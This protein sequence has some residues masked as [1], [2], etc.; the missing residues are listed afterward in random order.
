[1]SISS[2]STFAPFLN[3]TTA[4]CGSAIC[5]APPPTTAPPAAAATSFARAIR[6]DMGNLSH[7]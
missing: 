5:T 1:M 4:D 7:A 2:P 6:T 3:W